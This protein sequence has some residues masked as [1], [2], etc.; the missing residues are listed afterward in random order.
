[1]EVFERILAH[2]LKFPKVGRG[3]DEM[4]PEAHDFIDKLLNMDPKKRLGAQSIKEV[5][6]HPFFKGFDWDHVK[7]ME[8]PFKPAGRD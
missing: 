4:T 7:E 5:K 2:D 8:P 3:E 1:M 6:E